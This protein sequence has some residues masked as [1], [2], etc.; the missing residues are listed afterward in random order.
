MRKTNRLPTDSRLFF[1]QFLVIRASKDIVYRNIIEI[2]KDQQV[3]HWDSLK[4]TLIAGI[5]RLTGVKQ[6][7]DL[8]L[9]HIHILTQI[10]KSLKMHNDHA[11]SL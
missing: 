11:L 1:V 6:L 5:Y 4:A 10:P 7:C 9:V 2:R 3:L 8:S